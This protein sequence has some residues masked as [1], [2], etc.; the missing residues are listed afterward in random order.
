MADS[1]T[2]RLGFIG[3]MMCLI[4]PNTIASDYD[5]KWFDTSSIGSETQSISDHAINGSIGQFAPGP[6]GSKAGYKINGGFW[7]GFWTMQSCLADLN[8]DGELDFF[9]VSAFLVGFADMEPLA[10][11]NN[12]GLFNFFDVSVFLVAFKDGCP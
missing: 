7:P 11:F 9:D 6:S 5:I 1:M 10:D 8:G 12:D 2:K 3:T 4:T